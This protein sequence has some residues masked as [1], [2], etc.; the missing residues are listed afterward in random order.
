MWTQGG[1]YW[2]PCVAKC[3][4][5]RGSGRKEIIKPEMDWIEP[6]GLFPRRYYLSLTWIILSSRSIKIVNSVP[7]EL[8]SGS[9]LTRC[10]SCIGHS[11][12]ALTKMIDRNNLRRKRFVL[13]H[14]GIEAMVRTTQFIIAWIC[15]WA[16][17]ITADE[18]TEQSD[19]GWAIIFKNLSLVTAFIGQ[20][21][22]SKPFAASQSS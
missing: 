14:H 11:C 3:F 15:D 16:L 20:F 21:F 4:Y 13:L 1:I 2:S 12:V 5:Y 22:C 18:E 7:I 8:S 17:N 10:V 6:F 19:Q 9:F